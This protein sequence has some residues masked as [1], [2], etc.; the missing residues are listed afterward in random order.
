MTKAE[1]R[2]ETKVTYGLMDPTT[3][4]FVRVNRESDDSFTGFASDRA[5]LTLDDYGISSHRFEVKD[6]EP[7][8]AALREDTPSYNSSPTRP[9]WGDLDIAELQPV[10]FTTTETFIGDNGDPVASSSTCERIELPPTFK[11]PVHR[12][13]ENASRGVME[14]T[15]GD[16]WLR[17][18]AL[19]AWIQVML[20]DIEKHDLQDGMLVVSPH[21]NTTQVEAIVPVPED[22]PNYGRHPGEGPDLSNPH[23]R[24][25][26]ARGKDFRLLS[27]PEP[28]VEVSARGPR[29]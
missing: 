21:A 4:R 22:W 7:L 25:V 10:R 26:L 8:A 29:P 27:D 17:L 11:G 14:R 20:V 23:L 2:Q 24:L 12:T 3:A 15:F 18:Q 1:F 13:R 6:I 16:A 9:S 5:Y 19:D 28:L